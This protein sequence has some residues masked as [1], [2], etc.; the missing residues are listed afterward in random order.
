MILAGIRWGDV[1]SDW[2]HWVAADDR[3]WLAHVLLLAT[4]AN[5]LLGFFYRAY[6]A[7]ETRG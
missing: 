1:L 2:T 3:T 6:F 4:P 5:L 7:F